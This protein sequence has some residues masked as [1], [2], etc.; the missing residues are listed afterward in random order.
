M[1]S[2]QSL[3]KS[4]RLKYVIRNKKVWTLNADINAIK[5]K[6]VELNQQLF[7]CFFNQ[8]LEPFLK[9]INYDISSVEETSNVGNHHSLSL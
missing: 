7:V 4:Y 2:K 5:I 1:K 6:L 3:R 9:D 8:F